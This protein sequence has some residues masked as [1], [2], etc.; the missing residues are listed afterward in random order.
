ME[1]NIKY[2]RFCPNI[3]QVLSVVHCRSSRQANQAATSCMTRYYDPMSTPFDRTLRQSYRAGHRNG[4]KPSVFVLSNFAAVERVMP[5]AFISLIYNAQIKQRLSVTAEQV[6]FQ[7]T[8]KR[9]GIS[10]S[11]HYAPEFGPNTAK[12]LPPIACSRC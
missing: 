5:P 12:P 1:R 3:I 11:T 9:S 10:H 7:H 8:C 6:V 2:L 4:S